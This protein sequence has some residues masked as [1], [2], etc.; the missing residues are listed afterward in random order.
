MLSD[1]SQAKKEEE[2]AIYLN[3]ISVLKIEQFLVLNK[4][5]KTRYVLK[6]IKFQELFQI[7]KQKMNVCNSLLFYFIIF[8]IFLTKY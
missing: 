7:V 4:A 3:Y 1:Q 2:E 5:L 8:F 6:N